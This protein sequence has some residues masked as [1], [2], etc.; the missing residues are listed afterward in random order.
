MYATLCCLATLVDFLPVLLAQA[1]GAPG[2]GKTPAKAA[3]VP[4]TNHQLMVAGIVAFIVVLVIV[5]FIGLLAYAAT[6]SKRDQAARL[7]HAYS[8]AAKRVEKPEYVAHRQ[9]YV[10][11]KPVAQ[12]TPEPVREAPAPS[13]STVQAAM[14]L[15]DASDRE[16]LVTRRANRE[17]V[18]RDAMQAAA[19]RIVSEIVAE[20]QEPPF[21]PAGR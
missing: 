4:W 3:D 6:G 8:M 20:S 15:A 14:S 16:E 9:E 1:T 21:V 7:D 11:P 10:A 13:L 18:N 12:P 17:K 19:R 2:R 5:L